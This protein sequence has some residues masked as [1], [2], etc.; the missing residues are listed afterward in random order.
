MIWKWWKNFKRRRILAEPFPEDLEHVLREHLPVYRTLSGEER[1][2]IQND[3]RILMAEKHWE[4][5]GGLNLTD[6]MKVLI[7]AQ[8]VLLILS[9]QHDY[10]R[11]VGSILVYPDTF[12]AP[13]KAE[14]PGGMVSESDVPAHGQAVS[15]GTV[16]L[17]W[18]PIIEGAADPHDG[19]NVVFHEFAHK[20]DML[21]GFVDGTPPLANQRQYDAWTRIMTEHYEQLRE[22][23]KAG[24]RTLLDPYAAT[25]PAEFFAVATEC[26]F[27][28]GSTLK[29]R[30]PDLYRLLA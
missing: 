15:S 2:K 4:G 28:I 1:A 8:A 20:L 25:N 29:R 17:A 30:H 13:S 16:I 6:R 27:E 7:A 3:S 12:I 9:L 24:R 26:F 23:L 22:D 10:Y 21:D 11:R 19:R 18:T 14:G 5:C